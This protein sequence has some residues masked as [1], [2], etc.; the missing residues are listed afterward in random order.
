MSVRTKCYR[1]W[2]KGWTFI[3]RKFINRKFALV[4]TSLQVARDLRGW[5]KG[6]MG[7]ITP[8]SRSALVPIISL[9]RFPLVSSPLASRL[10]RAPTKLWQSLWRRQHWRISQVRHASPLKHETDSERRNLFSQVSTTVT[11]M[12]MM[13]VYKMW[14]SRMMTF[15]LYV[16]GK[17]EIVFDPSRAKNVRLLSANRI[18]YSLDFWL[19][20][21]MF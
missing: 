9:S 10:F 13:N 8:Y 18:L 3:N 6:V 14:S 1:S 4:S 19:P 16:F 15:S 17:K 12:E 20:L 11:T 7:R 2:R 21:L 5:T